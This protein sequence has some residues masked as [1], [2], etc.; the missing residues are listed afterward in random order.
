MPSVASGSDD[1]AIDG[2]TSDDVSSLTVSERL[3]VTLPAVLRACTTN[4]NVPDSVGVPLKAPEEL[5]LRPEGK[6]PLTR[7]QIIGVDPEADSV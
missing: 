4:V 2:A 7:D 6:L 1:V 5:S 3:C